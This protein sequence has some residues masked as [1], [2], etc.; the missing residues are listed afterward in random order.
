MTPLLELEAKIALK[1]LYGE[2]TYEEAADQETNVLPVL[3]YWQKMDNFGSYLL[4]HKKEIEDIISR[5]L[6][7]KG[8]EKCC[9]SP[10]PEWNFGSFNLCLPVSI[11]NW[12]K[13]PGG[14]VLV[15]FALPFK[16][17]E[18]EF[19]GNSDEKLRSEVATYA[20]IG[21]NCPEVPIPYL[22]GFAFAGGPSVSLV[23]RLTES[24]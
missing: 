7:L 18:A 23:F 13:R 3:T 21:K 16:V 5:Y 9:L 4:E 22:W 8:T 10:P 24:I 2:I 11:I 17:G 12:K 1:T 14:R 20:W 15:R 6:C 19:P